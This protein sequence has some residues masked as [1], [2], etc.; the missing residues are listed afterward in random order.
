MTGLV[1]PKKLEN[2][3]RL[4]VPHVLLL[5][6]LLLSLVNLP[7]PY[8]GTVKPYLVLMAVYYWSIYRPTLVPPLLCFLMGMLLDIISGVPMGLNAFILVGVQ[9]LVRDQRR[10]LMGQPY[11]TTWLVFGLVSLACGVWQWGLLGL[12]NFK[13]AHPLPGLVAVALS[14]LLFPLVTLLLNLTHR[15]LP[16]AS[17]P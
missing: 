17:R 3:L 15:I 9:W 11:M 4:M 6:L 7:L 12:V 16:V 13:W 10:F 2:L 5:V 14:I 1:M 8:V